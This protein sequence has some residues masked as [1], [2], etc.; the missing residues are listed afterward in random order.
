M[1][2]ADSYSPDALSGAFVLVVDADKARRLLV[3]GILRYCGAFVID[4]ETPQHAFGVMHLLKPDAVVIDFS[5]PHD[6]VID[7]TTRA[8]AMSPEDGGAVPIIAIAD[9]GADS[10]PTP[11]FDACLVRP[12]EPW[13]LCRVIAERL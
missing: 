4:V 11:P 13:R 5:I 10:D 8:R 2:R 12:L 9:A 6:T 7:F 1:E 3:V